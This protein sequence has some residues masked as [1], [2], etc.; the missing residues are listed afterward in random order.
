MTVA[1]AAGPMTGMNTLTIS[2]SE[3][4]LKAFRVDL[5]CSGK[6]MKS[7]LRSAERA[8]AET[9]Y[10]SKSATCKEAT[11]R[12]AISEKLLRRYVLVS[13]MSKVC[14]GQSVRTG[15]CCGTS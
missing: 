8:L 13:S 9:N 14:R 12:P 5:R 11:A 4:H 10:S 6:S 3:P 7:E 1:A 15:A 2:P